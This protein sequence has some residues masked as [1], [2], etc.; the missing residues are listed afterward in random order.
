MA[1]DKTIQQLP[2]GTTINETDE[3]IISE[4]TNA[5][6]EKKFSA[7]DIRLYSAIKE[8]DGS[9][10]HQ[11]GQIVVYRQQL[12]QALKDTQGPW[13]PSDWVQIPN[14]TTATG[15]SAYDNSV[16]YSQDELVTYQGGIYRAKQSTQGNLPTNTT[17]WE[18]ITKVQNGHKYQANSYVEPDDVVCYDNLWLRFAQANAM[19]SRDIDQEINEGKWLPIA[20][21]SIYHTIA[22]NWRVHVTPYTQYRVYGNLTVEDG[23]YF[24]IHKNAVVQIVDGNLIQNGRV[25]QD[26]TINY[27]TT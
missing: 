16:T 3:L 8:Y 20:G 6:D 15:I 24:H 5:G 19:I 7:K 2:D 25:V 11:A 4:G 27:I 1:Q 14:V 12:Y 18:P 21:Y 26:G 13:Q 17:Y 9:K 23:G 10:I 22:P